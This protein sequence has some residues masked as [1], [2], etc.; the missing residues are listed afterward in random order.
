[1]GAWPFGDEPN[2]A[3]RTDALP[4]VMIII[5]LG[6]NITSSCPPFSG[7]TSLLLLGL[8]SRTNLCRPTSH[9]PRPCIN[10]TTSPLKPLAYRIPNRLPFSLHIYRLSHPDFAAMYRT[11]HFKWKLMHIWG[12]LS[13][14]GLVVAAAIGFLYHLGTTGQA[15]SWGYPTAADVHSCGYPMTGRY[16]SSFTL[17]MAARTQLMTCF[18]VVS[19]LLSD[20]LCPIPGRGHHQSLTG[21]SYLLI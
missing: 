1:M 10:F 13:H 7:R 6:A 17:D 18:V 2:H 19:I 11:K 3:N 14:L 16:G 21:T 4:L 20:R 9:D 15:A 5:H 12:I 8:F